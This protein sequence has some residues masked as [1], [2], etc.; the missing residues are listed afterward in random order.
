MLIELSPAE[1]A[2]ATGGGEPAQPPLFVVINPGSGEHDP[3]YT[4]RLL[5][6]VFSE[7]G[8]VAQFSHVTRPTLL[9]QA[10]EEAAAQ[11]AA[12][13]GIL[14]AAG[15]DGTINSAARAA[16]SHGCPLAVIPQG[17]FNYVARDHGIPLDGEA[18]AR[19]LLQAAPQPVQVG[20]VNGE[21]FLVNASLGLYPQLLQD[22]EA[23]KARLGR[24]RW[25]ALIAGLITLFQWRRQLRLEVELEGR[26]TTI[27]TSTLFVGNNRLQVEQVGIEEQLTDRIGSGCLAGIVVR[28]IGTWAMLGLVLRGALGRL[29]DADH[30]RSFSFHTMDVNVLGMRL[31]KVATDG[32][33]QRMAPPLRFSVAAK[34][35]YLMLAAPEARAARE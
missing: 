20:L 16:L 18:A 7:A 21:V 25:V 30:V 27:A 11:A 33:V 13:G 23:F 22:R 1:A 17:T 4:E 19:A 5:S 15:G 28:P 35:L 12:Q 31:V 26:R 9:V 6:G 14:V 3:A 29:G 34:P 24:H 32:E 10:C 2:T 8:R